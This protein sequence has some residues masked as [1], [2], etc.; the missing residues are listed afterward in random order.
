MI[1]KNLLRV[2]ILFS[3]AL[4]NMATTDRD[5]WKWELTD[6][7]WDLLAQIKKLLYVIIYIILIFVQICYFLLIFNLFYRYFCVPHYISP[8][9]DIQR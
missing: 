9:G 5:L 1:Y 4:D 7:E 6:E 8:T 2:I 3:K